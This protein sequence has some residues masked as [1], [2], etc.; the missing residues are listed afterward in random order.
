MPF[1]TAFNL[2][3]WKIVNDSYGH[4]EVDDDASGNNTFIGIYLGFNILPDL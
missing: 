4:I 1:V 2:E 3:G